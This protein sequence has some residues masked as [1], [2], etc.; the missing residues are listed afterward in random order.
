MELNITFIL[1]LLLIYHYHYR[2][3]YI[4]I[5]III[6]SFLYV[7]PPPDPESQCLIMTQH[8]IVFMFLSNS[9]CHT[10]LALLLYIVCFCTIKKLNELKKTQMLSNINLSTVILM[11]YQRHSLL[12]QHFQCATEEKRPRGKKNKLFIVLFSNLDWSL[13]LLDNTLESWSLEIHSVWT[14]TWNSS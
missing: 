10:W 13:T 11:S 4:I 12:F 6:I 3:Y 2:Q 14:K 5:I 1:L 8:C 9:W 7:Y